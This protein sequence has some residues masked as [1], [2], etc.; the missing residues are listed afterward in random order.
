MASLGSCSLFGLQKR[1]P[2]VDECQ[3]A[4]FFSA[5]RISACKYVEFSS[6]YLHHPHFHARHRSV[7]LPLCC[8]LSHDN[9]TEL[10][11]HQHPPLTTWAKVI[12]WDTLLCKQPSGM[13]NRNMQNQYHYP[14]KLTEHPVSTQDY[15]TTYF[16]A[17]MHNEIH[18]NV[19]HY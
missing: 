12:K 10:P 16:G 2:S 14:Y 8:H 6:I 17:N 15:I 1:S 13:T 4:S 11:Y 5:W 18:S 19:Q 9:N 3:Q 7:R